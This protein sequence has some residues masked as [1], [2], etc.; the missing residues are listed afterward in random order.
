MAISSP[1]SGHLE[2][3]NQVTPNLLMRNL[4]SLADDFNNFYETRPVLKAVEGKDVKFAR[5]S[6]V[7]VAEIV[8]TKSL[9][10][11]GIEPLDKM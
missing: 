7:K 5:L 10:L 11:M 2:A 1:F 3:A 9:S 8:L 6:L 4:L